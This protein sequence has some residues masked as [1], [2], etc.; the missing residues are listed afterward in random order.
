VTISSFACQSIFFHIRALWWNTTSQALKSNDMR[1]D[2]EKQVRIKGD[3]QV[4]LPADGKWAPDDDGENESNDY[5]STA[6]HFVSD[7]TRSIGLCRTRRL[8]GR[9]GWAGK[10]TQKTVQEAP[11]IYV[12]WQSYCNT[13][14]FA[15][16]ICG[17]HQRIMLRFKRP[18]YSTLSSKLPLISY[19]HLL[20]SPIKR[21][22]S[23]H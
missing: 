1:P 22:K 14:C 15:E 3:Y 19:T 23:T 20:L 10:A 17:S 5:P 21:E 7:N 4:S 16:W 11:A 12:E 6:T 13:E 9:Q 8:K 18:K 2:A